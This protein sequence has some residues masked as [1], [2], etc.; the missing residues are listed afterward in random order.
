L[1]SPRD[2]A[3]AA[4]TL[5]QK[6]PH[7]L[8]G[9]GFWILRLVLFLRRVLPHTSGANKDEYKKKERA[10]RAIRQGFQALQQRI[11]AGVA[12]RHG[13]NVTHEFGYVNTFT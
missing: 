13:V 1:P 5:Q 9:A 8:P 2:C 10:A 12:V 4:L 3:K 6:T 11:R 7:S